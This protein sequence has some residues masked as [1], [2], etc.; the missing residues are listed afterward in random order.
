MVVHIT[1]PIGDIEAFV[2]SLEMIIGAVQERV[3]VL[4]NIF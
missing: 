3:A 4:F 2:T 1:F